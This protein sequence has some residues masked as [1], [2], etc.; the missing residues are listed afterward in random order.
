[1]QVYG[2]GAEEIMKELLHHSP[3]FEEV[4]GEVKDSRV[5]KGRAA[6]IIPT[7]RNSEMLG[8]HIKALERQSFQDFDLIIVYGKDDE[9]VDAPAIHIREKNSFGCAGAFYIGEKKALEEGH[10]TVILADDDAL[11]ASED[12]VEKLVE[13]IENGADVAYPELRYPPGSRKYHSR[14]IHHYGCVS[15]K[16]LHEAGLTYLP[17]VVGGEDLELQDRLNIRKY[18]AKDVDAVAEHPARLPVQIDEGSKLHNY[19]RGHLLS[20]LIGNRHYA[21]WRYSLFNIMVGIG[22]LLLGKRLGWKFISAMWS[23]AGMRFFKEK[24]EKI[25]PPEPSDIG[26]GYME[27]SG[28]SKIPVPQDYL[29]ENPGIGKRIGW[30]LTYTSN[31]PK[32]FN[33]KILFINRNRITPDILLMLLSRKS[34]LRFIDKEYVIAEEAGL[35]FVMIRSALFVMLIPFA[36]VLSAALVAR[37]ALLKRIHRIT[38]LG[39]GIRF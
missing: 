7:Y 21:A 29:S 2:R 20:H 18:H 24:Q 10:G 3:S 11:P 35:P 16:V 38:T 17:F 15:S 9:F 26:S 23:A 27:I 28:K 5:K 30:V 4:A 33:R 36:M 8:K 1:M 6:I 14:I 25:L 22:F 39:Y 34:A 12:L 13:A 31:L 32:F 37:G 19:Q